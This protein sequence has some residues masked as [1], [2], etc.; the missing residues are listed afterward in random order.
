MTEMIQMLDI[1]RA[2]VADHIAGLEREAAALRS[3]RERDHRRGHIVARTDATDHP[4]DVAS[5]RVRL[6]RWL[7]AV[8]E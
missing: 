8:G 3:E 4:P 2:S 6:G 5:R 7:V 1:Q